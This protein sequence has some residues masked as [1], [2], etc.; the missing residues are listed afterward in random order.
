MTISEIRFTPVMP[1]ADTTPQPVKGAATVT[2]GSLVQYSKNGMP[3]PPPAQARPAQQGRGASPMKGQ[4][5]P[6]PKTQGQPPARGKP[7]PASQGQKA[8]ECCET[9]EKDIEWHFGLAHQLSNELTNLNLTPDEMKWRR[10]EL[11]GVI[12]GYGA[13][14][15]A[16][17][18]ARTGDAKKGLKNGSNAAAEMAFGLL[19]Q[20][21]SILTA[22]RAELVLRIQRYPNAP[23]NPT[24]QKTIELI[25]A[26]LKDDSSGFQADLFKTPVPLVMPKTKD[27]STDSSAP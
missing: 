5:H 2:S 20:R 13:K 10:S 19:D 24:I 3:P 26:R 25:D 22:K 23:V 27:A 6:A 11:A 12:A 18:T 17:H 8:A 14:Q 7:Q 16:L 9:L 1:L 15:I 4:P 21:V